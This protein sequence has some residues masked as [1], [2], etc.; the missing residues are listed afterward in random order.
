LSI[1][2]DIALVVPDDTPT[3]GGNWVTAVRLATGLRRHGLSAGVFRLG[4]WWEAEDQG[5]TAGVIHAFNAVQ[6]GLSLARR[7]DRRRRLVVTWTGTDVLSPGLDAAETRRLLAAVPVHTVLTPVMRSQLVQR[8]GTGAVP[9]R[10][11]PPGVDH[12]QF[13]PDG[14]R[15]L[16]PHPVAVWVGAMR[17]VKGTERAVQLVEAVRARGWKL[18]LALV[19]PPRDAA[20]WERIRPLL[21]RRPWIR[22]AGAVDRLHMPEWYRAADVVINTSDSEGLSNALMEALAVGRPVVARDVPGNR[23]LLEPGGLGWLFHDAAD[24]VASVEEVLTHPEAARQRG[25]QA[26]RYMTEHF[27][28]D[29]EVAQFL[30]LY[31][32]VEA[33]APTV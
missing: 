26:R 18:A 7:E 6:V 32:E 3:A 25:E 20:Y 14:P 4:E 17:P 31:C 8:F 29:A 24:F 22:L 13:C 28:P 9:F 11:I 1:T 23:A 27:D 19:G 10:L 33:G 15:V 30:A 2:Y 5:V 21:E 12:R 16:L